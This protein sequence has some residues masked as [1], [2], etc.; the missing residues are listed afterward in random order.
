MVPQQRRPRVRTLSSEF[1]WNGASITGSGGGRLQESAVLIG[2]RLR[3][4]AGRSSK[5]ATAR[6][7]PASASATTAASRSDGACSAGACRA[8]SCR[9]FCHALRL[10]PKSARF[11][12]GN[13]VPH[14]LDGFESNRDVKW[15]R[16]A[17][18]ALD[19]LKRS[20]QASRA[21]LAS[22]M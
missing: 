19:G 3:P 14:V 7:A 9:A 8:R 20:I 15:S 1:A 12:L 5:R 16:C 13:V 21:A 4:Q 10:L 11:D 2:T 22:V 17:P 18:L 6:A